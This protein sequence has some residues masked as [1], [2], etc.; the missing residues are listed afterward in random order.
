[1]R[2][3]NCCKRLLETDAGPIHRSSLQ[4]AFR[5]ARDNAGIRKKA[6]VHTLRHSYATHLLE[7]GVNL[8]LI[9]TFLGHSSART[10]QICTHLSREVCATGE[11][12]VDR[13]MEWPKQKRG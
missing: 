1:M 2:A 7:D 10:T 6:H 3:Q 4:G 13:L 5:R 8:R 12:P 9:Q 11:D